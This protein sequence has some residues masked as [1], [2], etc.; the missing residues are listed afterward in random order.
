MT[1][2]HGLLMFFLGTGITLVGFFVAYLVVSYNH[3]K[4]NTE[5]KRYQ[6]PWE[7]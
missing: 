1:F 5:E 3:E 6:F 7:N 4:Q 2:E